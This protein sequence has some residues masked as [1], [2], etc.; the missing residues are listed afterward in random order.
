MRSFPILFIAAMNIYT[1]L[2]PARVNPIGSTS[3][4][5]VYRELPPETVLTDSLPVGFL[6][7]VRST[8]TEYY[9]D[10]I[11]KTT[12]LTIFRHKRRPLPLSYLKIPGLGLRAR[13]VEGISQQALTHGPGHF[14]GTANPGEVGNCG[15]AAHSNVRGCDFFRGLHRLHP[16]SYI[17]VETSDGLYSYIVSSLHVT[18]PSDTRDLRPTIDRRLTLVTCTLPDGA[19]RL[20]VTAVGVP[21]RIENGA[22]VAS[23][24]SA[25]LPTAG[26]K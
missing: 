11:V 26:M 22:H 21:A 24:P 9:T 17:Y 1:L 2:A 19:N 8:S 18:R 15:L 12:R 23:A 13:V 25:P 10:H 4:P 6:R 14:P 20:I 16:G 7:S 3:P 5:V